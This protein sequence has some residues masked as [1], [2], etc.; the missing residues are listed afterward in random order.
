MGK[1]SES[2]KYGVIAGVIMI[3]LLLIIYFVDMTKLASLIALLIYLPLIF[4]MIW[5]GITIRREKGSFSGFGDAFLT[6]FIISVTAT[7]LMDTFGFV[8]FKVIDPD[9]PGVIKAKTI[10]S[11]RNMMEKFG[12]TDDKIDEAV[13]KIKD[14]DFTPTIASQMGRYAWS[15]AIGA[16]FSL[17]I[18]AFINR[19]EERPPVKMEG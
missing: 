18:G 13:Q 6:V 3:V 11:T 8:L 17:I 4:L 15:I 10:E 16:I 19:S 2:L 12:A 5:G 9:V 14:K 1:Y 7:V